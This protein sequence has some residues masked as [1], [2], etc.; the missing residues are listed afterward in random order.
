M[1]NKR[2]WS[3]AETAAFLGLR[4]Q[5]L[6]QKRHRGDG[7]AYHRYGEG[8]RARCAYDPEDVAAWLETRRFTSTSEETVRM[9][10]RE[11]AA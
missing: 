10:E 6:R 11:D 4:P 3:N 7:P 8:P 1:P 5:T 2:Y 9:T